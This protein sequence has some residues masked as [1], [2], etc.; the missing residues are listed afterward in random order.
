MSFTTAVMKVGSTKKHCSILDSL[1]Q[2]RLLPVYFPY[3]VVDRRTFEKNIEV[4]GQGKICPRKIV[5][6][7]SCRECAK[8]IFSMPKPATPTYYC[9]AYTPKIE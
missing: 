7:L 3:I 8:L 9:V 6:R 2:P 5:Q 1:A 4:Q